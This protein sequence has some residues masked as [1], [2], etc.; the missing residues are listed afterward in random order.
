MPPPDRPEE[1]GAPPYPSPPYPPPPYPGG[2]SPGGAYPGTPYPGGAYPGTPYPGTPYP[3]PPY[4]GGGYPAPVYA[5]F[6][7]RVGGW[8]IDFIILAIVTSIIDVPVNRVKAARIDFHV[9][10]T[11]NGVTTV[12][13]DHYSV[14]VLAVQVVVVLLYAGLLVG[15]GRGRTI[16]MMAVSARA[17]DAA[18]GSQIGFWR[19]VGRGAFEYLLFF[20]LFVPWVVD[21]LFPAWDRRRQTLHDKVS[22]TVVVK[23]NVASWAPPPGGWG[24]S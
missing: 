23:T 16:G 1:R 2:G 15:V 3:P 13:Q 9:S 10:T 24:G 8:L 11:A 6:W 17:V 14:L 21:M 22:R 7:A 20:V 4:P 12:H 5:G 19:A 18:D